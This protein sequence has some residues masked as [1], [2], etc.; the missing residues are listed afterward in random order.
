MTNAEKWKEKYRAETDQRV[1][2]FMRRHSARPGEV[3]VHGP[4]ADE[5]LTTAPPR[6]PRRGYTDSELKAL[7]EQIGQSGLTLKQFYEKH[8]IPEWRTRRAYAKYGGLIERIRKRKFKGKKKR[9]APK[10][11][12]KG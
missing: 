2:S 3:G 4:V 10:F 1:R 9:L 8:N 7:A 11:T 12:R 5:D 6:T